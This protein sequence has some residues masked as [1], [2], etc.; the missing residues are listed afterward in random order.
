M[1]SS[2][3]G[4]GAKRGEGALLRGTT[5]SPRLRR[6]EVA[7]SAVRAS[8]DLTCKWDEASEDCRRW[9]ELRPSA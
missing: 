3:R 5:S 2:R 6:A 1:A 4:D 8:R 9:K 7:P